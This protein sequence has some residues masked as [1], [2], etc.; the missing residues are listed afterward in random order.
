MKYSEQFPHLFDKYSKVFHY[1]IFLPDLAN[2]LLPNVW[3]CGAGG[4]F[5]GHGPG[6]QWA[7]AKGA[8]I[9]EAESRSKDWKRSI[10]C[11]LIPEI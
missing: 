1:L 11:S 8:N 10:T 6:Q 2:D 5:F 9:R 4:M 7:L 3:H